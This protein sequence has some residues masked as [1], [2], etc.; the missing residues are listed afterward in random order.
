VG[1]VTI[2]P[3]T[4]DT[5]YTCGLDKSKDASIDGEEIR[6]EDVEKQK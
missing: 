3:G 6:V 1:N 2:L 4:D 5:D